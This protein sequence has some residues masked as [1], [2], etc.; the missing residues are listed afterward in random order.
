M[1]ISQHFLK[2]AAVLF[3]SPSIHCNHWFLPV[4]HHGLASQLTGLCHYFVFVT[5]WLHNKHKDT[6]FP[7]FHYWSHRSLWFLFFRIFCTT[8]I[9]HLVNVNTIVSFL[10]PFLSNLE[11]FK[12]GCWKKPTSQISWIRNLKISFCCRV[13]T[14]ESSVERRQSKEKETIMAMNLRH[15]LFQCQSWNY[16]SRPWCDCPPISL[17]PFPVSGK[18]DRDHPKAAVPL[19]K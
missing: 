1:I 14:Q 7:V 4:V 19:W 8:A 11:Y 18:V 9:H 15:V 12:W 16:H 5:C 6:F 10:S 13:H 2:K 3:L 17:I